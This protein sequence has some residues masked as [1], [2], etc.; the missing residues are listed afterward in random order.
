MA[1]K[2]WGLSGQLLLLVS[3]RWDALANLAKMME[4]VTGFLVLS[5]GRLLLAKALRVCSLHQSRGVKIPIT[6]GGEVVAAC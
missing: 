4:A 2:A 5:P 6:D 3:G 1:G